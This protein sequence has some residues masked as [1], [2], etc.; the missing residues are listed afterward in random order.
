SPYE[1]YRFG[2]RML[3]PNFT[4]GIL[5]GMEGPNFKLDGRVALITGAGRGIGLGIARALASA[6]AAVAI[7]DIEIDVAKKE[8][9][10]IRE[11]GCRAIAVGGDITDLALPTSAV[12]QTV[13]E[14]GGLHI[15]INNAAIQLQKAWTEFSVEEITRQVNADFISPIL[16]CQQA[17]AVFRPQRFGRIINI[18]SIQ[19]RSGHP[20][21]LPYS[22]CNTAIENLPRG[23]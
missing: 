20:D 7:Q 13:G 1:R 14:L 3:E 9:N 4:P 8:A 11:E 18:G 21:M 16:F 10:R 2:T 17:A 19:A 6:G 22:M 5:A 12:G 23:L 15:L